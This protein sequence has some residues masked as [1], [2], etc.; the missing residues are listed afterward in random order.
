MSSEIQSALAVIRRY[1]PVQ[2]EQIPDLG[3]YMDQVI[4]FITRMYEPL[5][6]EDI[7]GYL[8][9]S[10]INNYV[11]SKLIPR[12]TGKKYSRE[13][14]ALLTMIVALKQT[15][16]MEDIRRMLAL[17]EGETVEALYGA[18]SQ[19]FSDVI[20]SMCGGIAAS[21]GGIAAPQTALDFAIL[22]CGYSAGC[23]AA[24]KG[25]AREVQ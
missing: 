16:S 19:R 23:A 14:I 7:H 25:E 20:Q 2:W 6:G 17:R 4:T 1:R 8:S 3:L 24:L 5:Y 11:K 21:Q 15:S 18:F 10:M 9:P 13:Q 12:P 22:A